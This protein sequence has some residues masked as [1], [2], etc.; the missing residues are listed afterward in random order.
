MI[1]WYTTKTKQSMSH[2]SG[3]FYSDV[4]KKYHPQPVKMDI[5]SDYSWLRWIYP[6][7]KRIPNCIYHPGY[8]R[9]SYTSKPYWPSILHQ[10]SESAWWISCQQAHPSHHQFPPLLL[11][12]Y[13]CIIWKDLVGQL[14][15]ETNQTDWSKKLPSLASMLKTT[16][17]LQ[18]GKM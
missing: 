2:T 13:S 3:N 7:T 10:P 11:T 5:C 6:I 16:R 18:W 14:V 9:I 12:Y 15:S 17:K 4:L 1:S 8:H